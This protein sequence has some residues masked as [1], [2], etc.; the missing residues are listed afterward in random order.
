MVILG[1]RGDLSRRK[2]LPAL[3][4]L[5]ADGLLDEGFAVLHP[6]LRLLEKGWRN[7]QAHKSIPGTN[8]RRIE[9][10]R[11]LEIDNCI[12]LAALGF[13][14]VPPIVVGQGIDGI[15]RERGR[16]VLDRTFQI[17]RSAISKTATVEGAGAARIEPQGLREVR[18]RQR[19]FPLDKMCMA[20]AN[21]M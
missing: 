9:Q 16:I 20:S 17:S 18:D 12:F 2:L 6:F 21:M 7:S 1:A 10:Q 13:V 15:E 5:A 11:R 19:G 4:L 8:Q 3:Y 14:D